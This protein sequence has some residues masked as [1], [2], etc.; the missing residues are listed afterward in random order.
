LHIFPLIWKLTLLDISLAETGLLLM[1]KKSKKA[2]KAMTKKSKK[3][4]KALTKKQN[5]TVSL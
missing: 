3:A 5:D 2:L 1:T 4:L